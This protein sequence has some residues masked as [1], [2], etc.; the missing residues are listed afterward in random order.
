MP[1][2]TSTP[3]A[4]SERTRAAAPV[5]GSSTTAR[6]FVPTRAPAEVPAGGAARWAMVSGVGLLIR[7]LTGSMRFVRALKNPACQTHGGQRTLRGEC[8]QVSTRPYRVD[9]MG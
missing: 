2:T 6:A 3:S 1:K 7:F 8:A 5:I 4:S 9:D